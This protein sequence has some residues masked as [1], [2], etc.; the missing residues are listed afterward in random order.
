MASAQKL[1]SVQ[2][3]NPLIPALPSPNTEIL[4]AWFRNGANVSYNRVPGSAAFANVSG[5]TEPLYQSTYATFVPRQFA[6]DTGIADTTA[7]R[8]YM[9]VYRETPSQFANAIGSASV[10][11]AANNTQLPHPTISYQTSNGML[12]ISGLV[13]NAAY[14][15]VTTDRTKFKFIAAVIGGG[16]MTK[17][18]NLTDATENAN[19]GPATIITSIANSHIHIGS[20]TPT[21]TA[22]IATDIIFAGIASSRLSKETI[23]GYY[24]SI[25][26]ILYLN[27]GLT[28]I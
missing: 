20:S 16:E 4:F 28:D 3:T 8:T 24:E 26:Q 19:L 11:I 2:A 13:G 12:Y 27:D 23:D 5:A 25:K 9:A 14:L 17:L 21:A 22:N 10:I 18:Y 15:P 1:N 7:S 6:I